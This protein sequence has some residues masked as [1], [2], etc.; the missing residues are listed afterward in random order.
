MFF[1]HGAKG[2]SPTTFSIRIATIYRL[3]DFV[4][5]VNFGIEQMEALTA[6]NEFSIR[7]CIKFYQ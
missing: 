3:C 4:F 5:W 2:S 6:R 1:V 7:D